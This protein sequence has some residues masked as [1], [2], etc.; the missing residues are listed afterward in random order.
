MTKKGTKAETKNE[1]TRKAKQPSLPAPGMER[2]KI[3]DIEDAAAEYLKARNRRQE[4]TK[5][6][7][8]RMAVL[9]EQLTKHGVKVYK[10][11]DDEGEEQVVEV[12]DKVKVT[13][14]KVTSD[15]ADAGE[16]EA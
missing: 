16:R 3:P 1:K 8:E 6:E 2:T 13:V 9:V 5:V 14:R 12:K 15:G 11:D 7:T 10:F 4:Q